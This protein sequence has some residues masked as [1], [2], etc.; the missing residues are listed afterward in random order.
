MGLKVHYAL[1]DHPMT[2]VACGF[3]WVFGKTKLCFFPE[4]ATCQLCIRKVQQWEKNA[5]TS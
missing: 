4:Q 2:E 5:K 1:H 3:K